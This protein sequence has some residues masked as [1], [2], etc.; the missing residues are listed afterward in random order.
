ML[1]LVVVG[2]GNPGARYAGTRHNIGFQVV[3]ALAEKLGVSFTKES[4]FF[5]RYG[6]SAIDGRKVHLLLPDTYMNESGRAVQALAAYFKV[7]V[8]EIV[9][10]QDD[11]AIPYGD[12]RIKRNGTSG[13]H[14]GLK[15]IE[16]SLGT[17][18]F[19]RLKVGVGD[20]WTNS[21]VDHVLAPFTKEES[22][23]LPA[24][25]ERAVFVLE[26][27]LHKDIHKVMTAVNTKGTKKNETE[28]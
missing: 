4:R 1:P 19:P 12:L 11:I 25:I 7:L 14:N 9:I 5:G 2:L 3:E 10:V 13:G 24:L 23:T 6:S 16:A 26:E 28:R 18:N 20:N 21:L 22:E 8:P 15:S 27:L 17:N